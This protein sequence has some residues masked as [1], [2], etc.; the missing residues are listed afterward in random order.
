MVPNETPQYLGLIQ[1]FLYFGWKWIGL[2]TQED[3]AGQHFLTTMELL[4]LQYGMCS[5]FTE[6]VSKIQRF[7]GMADMFNR[8]L[9]DIP[10]ILENKANAI[11][12]YGESDCAMDEPDQ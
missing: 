9:N 7:N 3:D 1:L 2:I 11:V 10:R 12:I 8:Y 4:L 5:A 6:I